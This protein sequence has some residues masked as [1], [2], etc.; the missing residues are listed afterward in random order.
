MRPVIGWS[1]SP[2]FKREREEKSQRERKEREEREQMNIFKD[3]IFDVSQ[4]IR[5]ERERERDVSHGH[6][7]RDRREGVRERERGRRETR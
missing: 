7:V 4:P 5:Q 3:S 2:S 6:I 1:P